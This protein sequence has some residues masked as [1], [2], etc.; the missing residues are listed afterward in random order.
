MAKPPRNIGA[1]PIFHRETFNELML[2]RFEE[3]GRLNK[4]DRGWNSAGKA[5]KALAEDYQ[6]KYPMER[7]PK[8]SWLKSFMRTFLEEHPD[9]DLEEPRRRRPKRS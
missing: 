2:K 9:L 8:S 6:A 3:N 1:P 4:A 5:A 7:V